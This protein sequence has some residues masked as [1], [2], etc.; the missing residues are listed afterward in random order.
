MTTATQSRFTKF[1]WRVRE[2]RAW[3]GLVIGSLV[4]S[5]ISL[6]W[7]CLDWFGV[8]YAEWPW[9][10]AL[11]AVGLAVGSLCG[12][13]APISPA[14]LADSIDR[15]ANLENRLG[16][17]QQVVDGEFAQAIQ[18]DAEAHL[19]AIRPAQI[20]PIR[21]G[22]QE[23]I[24][25]SMCALCAAIFLL[26]NSTMFLSDKAKRDRANLQSEAKNVERVTR[27]NLEQPEAK[28]DL[29]DQEKQMA[30]ELNRLS[31]DME[32]A[33][34]SKE[35]AQAKENDLAKKAD[36]L[37]HK[38]ADQAQQSLATAQS[39]LEQMERGELDRQGMRDASISQAQM[40]QS[41]L[42]S[43]RS[44]NK[45]KQADLR[46]QLSEI[47][48]RLAELRKKLAQKGLSEAERKELER[49]RKLLEA[50]RKALE[51]QLKSAEED[52]KA[53]ELSEEA[54]KVFQKLTQD[55]LF[56][57]LQELQAKMA[58]DLN[59][60]QQGQRPPLT[61]EEREQL[62]R[63]M[64]ELARQLKDDK[65]MKEYLQAMLDAMKQAK[66]MG[67]IRQQKTRQAV[68]K[69]PDGENDANG[70]GNI[71]T[72]GRKHIQQAEQKQRA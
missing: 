60:M 9:L 59:A 35:E 37:M 30:N 8:L 72:H 50:Q 65:A 20:Y 40:S 62:K 24:S 43:A 1:E 66:G 48:R 63:E 51:Q 25:A 3:K 55:P 54:R 42:Q 22:R 64:E 15:R 21:L 47:D 5:G 6:V 46:K 16:S 61:K 27:E 2:V 45:A 31:R 4:T 49:E 53:L 17:S 70:P 41:E 71:R 14:S 12:L 7:T 34:V 11:V 38:R 29:S 52:A 32:K 19:A 39:A 44:Q 57:K 58:K 69:H 28:Q 68:I 13:A 18:A 36:E 26:G 33:H 67:R 56:K 10:I 23:L